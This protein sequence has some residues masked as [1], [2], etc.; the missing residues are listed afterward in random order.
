MLVCP[1]HEADLSVLAS[2]MLVEFPVLR[3]C[4]LPPPRHYHLWNN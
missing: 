1:S 4:S 2:L 3:M